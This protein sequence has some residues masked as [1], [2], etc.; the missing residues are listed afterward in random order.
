ML[1]PFKSLAASQAEN[2]IGLTKV[3]TLNRTTLAKSPTHLQQIIFHAGRDVENRR[4][5]FGRDP[6]L[7][8]N[9]AAGAA[10]ALCNFD[11]G[12]AFCVRPL[13]IVFVFQASQIVLARKAHTQ[14]SDSG[15]CGD[16]VD[17]KG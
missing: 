7:F 8:S 15:V 13:T 1:F 14:H 17:H 11:M 2:L 12:R 9:T 4:R 3:K 6:P 5:L 10:S 16:R